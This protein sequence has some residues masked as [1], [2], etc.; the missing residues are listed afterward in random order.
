MASA[1]VFIGTT[2]IESAEFVS[3]LSPPSGHL[4]CKQNYTGQ[5][6]RE[7]QNI[8]EIQNN[9]ENS[10]HLAGQIASLER[11]NINNSGQ[12]LF[13]RKEQSEKAIICC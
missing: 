11:V 9:I 8:L 13:H 5:C 4:S 2:G 7:I 1:A 12:E 3:E 6:T 10:K